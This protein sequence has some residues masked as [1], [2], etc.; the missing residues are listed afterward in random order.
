MALDKKPLRDRI[1]KEA[2]QGA[3]D[4]RFG[5]QIGHIV[6]YHTDTE[7]CDCSRHKGEKINNITRNTMDI[8]L[9]QGRRK[10]VYYDVPCFIFNPGLISKGYREGDRVWVQFI[11]GDLSMPLV[12]GYYREPFVEDNFTTK[13]SYSCGESYIDME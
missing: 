2:V 4:A 1:V 12:T 3:L 13:S 6:N 11:N 5:G 9:S 8:Y 7:R 10:K